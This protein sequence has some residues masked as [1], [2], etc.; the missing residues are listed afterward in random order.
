MKILLINVVCGIR[1]TGRI[2]ADLADALTARGHEVKIAYGRETVPEQYQKYAVRIGGEWGVRAHALKA[3]LLDASGW[4]SRAATKAFIEWVKRFDPDVINLHNLQGYYI[5][6]EVLFDYLRTCGKKIVWTLHDFWAVTGHTT[7]CDVKNCDKWRTG[8]DDCP[9]LSLYPQSLT[10]HS[11]ANWQRKKALF[12]GVPQMTLVTP[13]RWLAG[14]IGASYLSSYPVTVIPN[15]I[16]TARFY[17]LA[18]DFRAF[19][20]LEGR[21][22]ILGAAKDGASLRTYGKL[23]ELLGEEYRLVLTGV[24]SA[25][26]PGL[27]ACVLALESADSPKEMEQ[28]VAAADLVVTL[29]PDE[30]K[31]TPWPGCDQITVNGESLDTAVETIWAYRE[32]HQA[33]AEAGQASLTDP[34]YWQYKHSLGLIGKRVLLGVAAI[35]HEGKGLKDIVALS[36]KTN[37]QVVVVGVT[38][39]QKQELPGQVLSFVHTESVEELRRLYAVADLFINPTYEDNFP[40]T[41]IEALACGTPVVTYQTGGSPESATWVVEKGDWAGL[42]QA[43]SLSQ[44]A[45]LK[46]SGQYTKETMIRGYLPV[47]LNGDK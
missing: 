20:G 27:P 47:L 36:Q 4:G 19:Y 34:G 25:Q 12:N 13:S 7:F 24:P 35:W 32:R 2:C 18:N 33:D 17:P 6:L 5:H 1:S 38:E 40:T 15:G 37:A 31:D 9:C 16:D 26:R 43:Q 21:F 3:R 11:R 28:V 42:D 46:K 41:N 10:D 22:V 29:N 44:A 39:A 45:C 14:V 30:G 8:C 23:A